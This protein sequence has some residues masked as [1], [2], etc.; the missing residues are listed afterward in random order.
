MFRIPPT[1]LLTA[2]IMLASALNAAA[3]GQCFPSEHGEIHSSDAHSLQWFG[4][5]VAGD[6][7]MAVSTALLDGDLGEWAGAAYVHRLDG[8]TWTEEAKLTASDGAGGDEF[9]QSVAA[10]GDLIVVGAHKNDDAC[11]TDPHCNSGA[12]YVFR[13]DG[14]SWIEEAKL[15]APDAEVRDQFGVSIAVRG[16][17]VVVGA[18]MDGNTGPG[19][20]DGHGSAY[21]FR[22]TD[23]D[24]SFEQKLTAPTPLPGGYY[25]FAVDI[26]GDTA[27]IGAHGHGNAGFASGAAYVYR[28]DG[29]SWSYEAELTASDGAS[30]DQ[31]GKALS[32]SGDVALLG[33]QQDDDACGVPG[34]CNSGAAYI[35]RRFGTTWIQETKLTASDTEALDL[36]GI[37][38]ALE[39]DV[40]LIGARGGDDFGPYSGAAYVYHFDGVTWN[41]AAKLMASD[42]FERDFFGDSVA[43]RGGTA[44]AGA[45][46]TDDACPGN[47]DCNSGSA[48]IF[49]GLTDC[50]GSGELDLCEIATGASPDADGDGMPD[51]CQSTCPADLDGNGQ[52]AFADLLALIGAWGPCTGCPED[53]DGDGQVGFADV[54]GLISAWGTCP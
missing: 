4:Y 3:A 14:S 12:A 34:S 21:V 54:L 7:D 11:P 40:A 2:P 24:W 1:P 25:G 41:E 17:L 16:D 38:V 35:F 26:E 37:S 33:A 22:H 31:L 28:F 32:I 18:H 5:R 30:L 42:G 13:F 6:G 48:Y 52:V 43:L 49:R 9:G 53:L 27:L 36:Y 39:N 10:H 45:W 50:D 51:S 19:L 8:G 46:R 20:F 23:G 44:F 29:A 15:T 47:P